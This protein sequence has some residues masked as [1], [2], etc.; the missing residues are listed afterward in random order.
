MPNKQPHRQKLEPK[1][2]TESDFR[3]ALRETVYKIGIQNSKIHIA[4]FALA[5]HRKLGM[6][7]D[8]MIDMLNETSKTTNE[9]LCYSDVRKQVLEETGLDIAEYVDEN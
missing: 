4:S 3:K 5:L 6:N 2:Y 8:Q 9:A 7:L 1:V